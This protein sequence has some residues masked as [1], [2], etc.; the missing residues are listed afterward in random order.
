MTL[1]TPGWVEAILYACARWD[2][3]RGEW[4]GPVRER[5]LFAT[6]GKTGLRLGECR[7]T[8]HCAVAP[9][10]PAE[11]YGRCVPAHNQ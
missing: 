9:P 1:L 8:R 7:S 5:L 10:G 4:A 11:G 6:L 3:A 2:V